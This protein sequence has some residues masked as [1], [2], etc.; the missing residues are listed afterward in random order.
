MD[1]EKTIKTQDQSRKTAKFKHLKY[2]VHHQYCMESVLRFLSSTPPFVLFCFVLC[3]PQRFLRNLQQ[4]IVPFFRDLVSSPR[5]DVVTSL[6]GLT[7][8]SPHKPGFEQTPA[9]VRYIAQS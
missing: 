7:G 4:G 5:G 8:G 6:P 2:A 3:G 9:G 1:V